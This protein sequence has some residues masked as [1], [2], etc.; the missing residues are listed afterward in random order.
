VFDR[1]FAGRDPNATLEAIRKRKLYRKSILDFVLDDAT[2]LRGRL[3]K[4]DRGK[5]DEYLTAVRELEQ[6]VTAMEEPAVCDPGMRPGDRPNFQEAIA[7]MSDLIVVAF[8]CDLTRVV[9]FM[10]GNAGSNRVYRNLGIGEGHHQISHHQDDPA[11]HSR[12]QQID[13]WEVQQLADLL[14]KMKAVQEPDG[15]LL[16]NSA[17]FF[18]SEIED[19]NSHSHRRL[20]VLL[21]GKGGGMFRPGRHVRYQGEPPIANLFIAMLQSVGVQVPTFGDDGNEPLSNLA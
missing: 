15:T 12:L 3:G 16:D 19:G 10:L 7:A 17:V 21:A 11:N 9:S 13:I 4:T 18:S 5:I 6:R 8:R 2:H 14:S 1:L 20:P